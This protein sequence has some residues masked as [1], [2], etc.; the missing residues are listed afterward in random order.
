[1]TAVVAGLTNVPLTVALIVVAP[2]SGRLTDRFGSRYI[3]MF[4]FLLLGIGIASVA[5]AESTKATSLTF[6][7]PLALTGLGM[8]SVI[9]PVMTEAMREVKPAMAG[10]ASGVLNTM[11]QLGSAVGLAL[12]GAVLQNQ[13]STALHDRAVVD[14][15]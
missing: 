11:R 4:G 10:A 12:I 1:M 2:F 13:L 3:L 7:I 5:L 6:V 8:G 15:A 9:A 14:S